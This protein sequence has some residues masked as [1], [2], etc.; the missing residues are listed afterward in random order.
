MIKNDDVQVV[1][2]NEDD[3]LIDIASFENELKKMFGGKNGFFEIN[4][5]SMPNMFGEGDDVFSNNSFQEDTAERKN[6]EKSNSKKKNLKNI[7]KFSIN[8]TQRARDNQ[9][10]PVIGRQK[11]IDRVIQILN[12][13][14]KNN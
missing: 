10:D 6:S 11:E 4:V 14:T 7:E 1:K 9:I 2:E 12:R 3:D 8:L 13:R 5:S